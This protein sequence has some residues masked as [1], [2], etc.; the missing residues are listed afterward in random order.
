MRCLS[1]ALCCAVV[2]SVLNSPPLPFLPT[3]KGVQGVDD[4]S[5]TLA[6]HALPDGGASLRARYANLEK[7]I[8][9]GLRRYNFFWVALE[10]GPPAAATPLACP[11]THVLT[12]ANESERV[13]LGYRLFHCYSR[14][15]I[16]TYDT[17]LA[18]DASIGTQSAFIMYG[19]PDWAAHPSC[20][21]FPWPPSPNYRLGCL[22][23]AAS[24][25]DAYHDYY[26]FS[27]RRWRGQ[28]TSVCVWNEVQSLGWSDPS[29]ILPNRH[30]AG[31]PGTP[32]FTPPQLALYAEMLSNLT[33]LA[34]EAA[35][36]ASPSA[37]AF[38]WLSTDHFLTAPK[39]APGDVGH[40]GLQELLDAMWPVLWA[41][42]G[43]G[44]LAWGLAVHPYD[45]GDPRQDLTAQGI[46]TF[47]TLH[48]AVAAFQCAKLG[49]VGVPPAHCPQRPETQMWASEQGCA[50]CAALLSTRGGVSL[51]PSAHACNNRPLPPPR[52]SPPS[53][54]A[55]I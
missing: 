45:G 35:R 43:Q 29:P 15:M 53:C 33:L 51:L 30:P 5:V 39:A 7:G 26:L 28:L 40:L 52:N 31:P 55:A 12:P 11:A 9:P 42:G 20:T 46:Y 47:G 22:P 10:G 17:F 13:A 4:Q 44:Q 48:K 41:R 21:G 32:M 50:C 23:W 27:L 49:E 18:L 14:D 19:V 2:G 16:S 54:R 34:G 24:A 37:P 3:L 38:A 25:Q 1:A 8:A 6:A 36:A